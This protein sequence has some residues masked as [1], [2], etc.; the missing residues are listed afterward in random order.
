MDNINSS[1]DHLVPFFVDM[2]TSRPLQ[3]PRMLNTKYWTKHLGNIEKVSDEELDAGADDQFWAGRFLLDALLTNV[4]NAD[5]LLSLARRLSG[6]SVMKEANC[7][8]Y[9]MRNY[10]TLYV[11]KMN[12]YVL[13]QPHIPDDIQQAL[14]G[15]IPDILSTAR[16]HGILS[17]KSAASWM[18]W[19][20]ICLDRYVF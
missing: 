13:Y 20:V 3:L 10:F 4:K 2:D 5:T 17:S 14:S 1:N 12:T 9:A 15:F 18:T 19:R 6:G 8:V 16:G 7:V 11:R